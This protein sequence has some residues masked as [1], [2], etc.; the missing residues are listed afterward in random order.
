LK[1]IALH[2]SGERAALITP[3]ELPDQRRRHGSIP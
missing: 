2:S 1:L 3:R